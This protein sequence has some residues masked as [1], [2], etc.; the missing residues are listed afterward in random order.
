MVS[1]VPPPPAQS[2]GANGVHCQEGPATTSHPLGWVTRHC[3]TG[4]GAAPGTLRNHGPRLAG[5]DLARPSVGDPVNEKRWGDE[6]HAWHW[7]NPHLN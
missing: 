3:A 5:K 4:P 6:P 1:R 7:V 2:G